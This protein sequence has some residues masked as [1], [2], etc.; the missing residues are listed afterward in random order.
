MFHCLHSMHISCKGCPRYINTGESAPRLVPKP[1]SVARF[2]LYMFLQYHVYCHVMRIL[3]GAAIQSTNC[4]TYESF[5]WCGYSSNVARFLTLGGVPY[6]SVDSA[7]HQWHTCLLTQTAGV[8]ASSYSRGQPYMQNLDTEH[9]LLPQPS[10]HSSDSHRC[11]SYVAG[12]SHICCTCCSTCR[13]NNLQ[14]RQLQV[15]MALQSD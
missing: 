8:N 15:S 10:V 9:P 1:S 13:N 2:D 14:K 3:S 11:A 7:N 12:H 5:I 6:P 4:Y